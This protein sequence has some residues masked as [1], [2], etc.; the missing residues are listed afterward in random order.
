MSILCRSGYS[1]TNGTVNSG[2]AIAIILCRSVIFFHILCTSIVL[3]SVLMIGF[4]NFPIAPVMLVITIGKLCI[5][6]RAY[7]IGKT[8]VIF[9]SCMIFG[10]GYGT[11]VTLSFV[12][13]LTCYGI[14][15]SIFVSL[16]FGGYGATSSTL[17][18]CSTIVVIGFGSMSLSRSGYS[19]ANCTCDCGGAIAIILCRS[20]TISRKRIASVA[21]ITLG[22]GMGCITT[23]GTSG[24][25]NYGIILVS[26]GL[27]S[28][29]LSLSFK[30]LLSKGGGVGLKTVL[31]TCGSF[32]CY[33]N[34]NSLGVNVRGV[35]LTYDA[36][37][38]LRF[39]CIPGVGNFLSIVVVTVR[40][41][42]GSA[43]ACSLAGLG[44][45]TGS[46]CPI[47]TKR[48][49]CLLR[50]V[51]FT[52]VKALLTL[53][54]TCGSTCRSYC[55]K[56]LGIG[57]TASSVTDVS[58]NVTLCVVNIIISM[59]SKSSLGLLDLNLTTYVTVLTLGETG[60]LAGSIH[61]RIGYIVV[62]GGYGKNLGS[63]IRSKVLKFSSI[64]DLT[65]ILTG[66]GSSYA[67]NI[68]RLALACRA[69]S[70]CTLL[71]CG[72]RGVID[73]PGI[74][75]FTVSV[76]KLISGS[77]LCLL[78]K[79]F[80]SKGSGIS[81]RSAC[82]TG[83]RC[84][85]D[86]CISGFG[87]N[88]T[89][90]VLTNH[91][92][93]TGL[94]VIAPNIG[95]IVVAM[96]E[97]AALG[98][99]TYRT[100]LRSFAGSVVPLV[101]KRLALS[102]GTYGA[103]LGCGTGCI[104]PIVAKR[105]ALSH[106]A[107]LSLTGL[108]ICAGCGL[109]VVAERLALGCLT[110]RAGLG[111]GTGC[112]SPG[113]SDHGNDLL[114]CEDLLTILTFQALGKSGLGTGCCLSRKNLGIGVTASCI[115]N[116]VTSLVV[117][118]CVVFIIVL[119]SC[120]GNG[121]LCLEYDVALRALLTCGKSGLGTGGCLGSESFLL[122]SCRRDGL[123]LYGDLTACGALLALGKS[124]LGT[125]CRLTLK[126]YLG[127]R[128]LCNGLGVGGLITAL[129]RTG[130]GLYALLGTGGS[131]RYLL[132]VLVGVFRCGLFAKDVPT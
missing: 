3:A 92:C 14:P 112:K 26:L 51:Y 124:C 123:L 129:Y 73:A 132:T 108:R 46:I 18:F 42:V 60:L 48:S 57:M 118:G 61:C 71:L 125:G 5:T 62:V 107:V 20:V 81:N 126:L 36:C 33:Y 50:N 49:F 113:V 102:C 104:L 63:C 95:C 68:S 94:V 82:G 84:G 13:I 35:S 28:L 72:T 45:E 100:G 47:V 106:A 105:L 67:G 10:L 22:A 75:G 116:E 54:L 12:I 76:I 117:T 16:S 65:C 131:L 25:G 27:D 122:M 130:K 1:A 80:L 64:N 59:G 86:S 111:R 6:Y 77:A 19:A 23:C 39:V 8:V 38:T 52:T 97:L 7:G 78:S 53:G 121:A 41:T 103:D 87:H 89:R 56:S 2:G 66:S 17:N 40:L 93:S 109:P 31:G 115:A 74:S 69:I 34:V 83:C 91:G 29:F 114:T 119:V 79:A 101:T 15:I 37:G 32:C 90:I 110:Y 98:C 128:K 96:T 99:L 24:I 43:T 127:V 70:S 30:A 9:L 44:R 85:L 55:S 11:I 58:A 88:V 120:C 4:C 21:I